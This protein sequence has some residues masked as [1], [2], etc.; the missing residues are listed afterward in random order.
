MNRSDIAVLYRT[1]A[2]GRKIRQALEQKGHSICVKDDTDFLKQPE[3]KTVLAYLY[4][5]D[6]IAHPRARGTEGW[7]RL[8]HY[9]HVLNTEDASPGVAPLDAGVLSD[10]ADAA[11]SILHDYR[12]GFDRVDDER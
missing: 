9:N 3:I 2:Q 12:H 10:M 7:W 11:E 8:F 1:H 6:N 5:L 4:V